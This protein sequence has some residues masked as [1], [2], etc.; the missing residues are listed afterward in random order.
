MQRCLELARNGEL[1]T[2][3]NP[4]VGAVIVHGDGKDA[5]ILGEGYHIRPGEGHAEVNAL[6]NVRQADRALLPEATIYVSLE[7]C[8]HF[9]RTPPCASL[10]VR[11]GIRKC[12]VG[13]VD[14]FSKVGGRGLEILREGGV[15]VTVGVL[16]EACIDLNRKFFC[17]QVLHHPEMGRI[18]R[19]VH[20]P[21]T[22]TRRAQTAHLPTGSAEQFPKFAARS[23]F[24]RH[25]WCHFG[26]AAHFRTRPPSTQRPPVAGHIAREMRA[27]RSR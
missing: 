2:A 7:P 14:P 21:Q 23:L 24:A 4:M 9:G 18:G 26:G 20:R 22:R 1:T 15:E 6:K 11:S 25:T 5:R 17:Q 19:R 13:C 3:P 27:G 12:V 16:R 10:I 8:A